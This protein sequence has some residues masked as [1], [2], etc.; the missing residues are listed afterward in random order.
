MNRRVVLAT[1]LSVVALPA[2]NGCQN[3]ATVRDLKPEIQ[4]MLNVEAAL[5]A[6][7]L[8]R[9]AVKLAALYAS[10]ASLYVPGE[11]K[12]RIGTDAILKGARK[13]LADPAFNVQFQSE[14]VGAFA[15]GNAGYSKGRFT[16]HYVDPRTKSA[17]HYSGH[18]LT[19][20]NKA[21]DGSWKIVENMASPSS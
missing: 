12:P 3:K 21:P 16:V 19:L 20:F 5:R 2:L 11:A 9:D 8:T 15:P 17:A 7:Y 10:D 13:D 18:Y 14:Q 4:A 1:A 6:A